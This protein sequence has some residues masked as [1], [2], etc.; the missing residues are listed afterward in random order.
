[1]AIGS[2]ACKRAICCFT[3][4]CA[5]SKVSI[6]RKACSYARMASSRR[7]SLSEALPSRIAVPSLHGVTF[8]TSASFAAI[9][10]QFGFGSL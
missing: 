9:S 10:S 4:V 5:R 6:S 1:V 2:P 3:S 7:S 8:R